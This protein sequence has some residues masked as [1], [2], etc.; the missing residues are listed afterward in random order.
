[1]SKEDNNLVKWALTTQGHAALWPCDATVFFGISR[2]LCSSDRGML[3]Y[4]RVMCRAMQSDQGKPRL[5]CVFPFQIFWIGEDQGVLVPWSAVSL[6]A[7]SLLTV[8][9][10]LSVSF[11]DFRLFA[12]SSNCC[13]EP[14]GT[15]SIV[16]WPPSNSRYRC[17]RSLPHSPSYLPFEAVL[18]PPSAQ[19]L[20]FADKC[21]LNVLNDSSLIY[22][23]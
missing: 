6:L 10:H 4:G 19:T 21:V 15:K 17:D 22:P 5:S 13:I 23:T 12:I 1:M 2:S 18:F 14:S 11:T 9:A 20:P 7:V 3:L 16:R 8:Q